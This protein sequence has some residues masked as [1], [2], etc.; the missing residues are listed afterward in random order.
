M[1]SAA[2]TPPFKSSMLDEWSLPCELSSHKRSAGNK[3][4]HLTAEAFENSPSGVHARAIFEALHNADDRIS[5]LQRHD[6]QTALAPSSLSEGAVS[7]EPAREL[8]GAGPI[9][10]RACSDYRQAHVGC[11]GRKSSSRCPRRG[12]MSREAPVRDFQLHGTDDKAFLSNRQKQKKEKGQKCRQCSKRG[13]RMSC[14]DL[15][16]CTPCVN[17]G[18]AKYCEMPSRRYKPR[19]PSSRCSVGRKRSNELSWFDLQ[20]AAM[21]KP[22]LPANSAPMF[23]ASTAVPLDTLP[24]KEYFPEGGSTAG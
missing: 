13:R 22:I 20:S 15:E 19:L 2:D 6:E 24:Q 23:V 3:V 18:L 1:H 21:R 7:S 4:E 16:P 5:T 10:F 12:E 11:G 9:I 17:N 8:L 14:D